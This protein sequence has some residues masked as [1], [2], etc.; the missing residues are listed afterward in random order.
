[1]RS[2]SGLPQN[3][4]EALADITTMFSRAPSGG[5]QQVAP[6]DW[7]N[8][9]GQRAQRQQ[10]GFAQED[11]A[12]LERVGGINA[13]MALD[14]QQRANL[15]GAAVDAYQQEAGLRQ[16]YEQQEIAQQKNTYDM[17]AER[18]E[19][20]DKKATRAM[21]VLQSLIPKGMDAA[22]ITDDAIKLA[23]QEGSF[24]PGKGFASEE[25]MVDVV[26]RTMEMSPA[27]AS[28]SSTAIDGIEENLSY[29]QRAEKAAADESA[30]KRLTA[31]IMPQGSTISTTTLEDGRSQAVLTLPDGSQKF[32]GTPTT[33]GE[34]AIRIAREKAGIGTEEARQRAGISIDTA[35]QKGSIA[36][37]TARQ[38]QA[39]KAPEEA[40]DSAAGPAP[41][42]DAA[43]QRLD[44]A[45]LRIELL[46]SKR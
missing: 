40:E 33:T 23:T 13:K 17:L 6:P 1:M 34:E 22:L 32:M 11:A 37:D 24:V 8:I 15:A 26:R 46:E 38:K 31:G 3:T 4:D 18:A 25:A 14:Q 43:I 20:G 42:I 19:A 12:E 30:G 28:P 21:K 35:R 16:N 5:G 45:K 44:A 29:R 41:D 39:L 36:V 10:Q 2:A 7:A 9:Y 27:A